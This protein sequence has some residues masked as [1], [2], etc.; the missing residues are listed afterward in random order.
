[1]PAVAQE[2]QGPLDLEVDIRTSLLFVQFHVRGADVNHVGAGHI[3][4]LT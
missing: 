3:A 1:M 4:V 2:L